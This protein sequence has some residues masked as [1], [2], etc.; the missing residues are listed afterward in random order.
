MLLLELSYAAK[1]IFTC[2]MLSYVLPTVW[3]HQYCLTTCDEENGNIYTVIGVT[4][5]DGK[6]EGGNTRRQFVPIFI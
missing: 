3:S 6:L 4:R 5:N 1:D 2:D